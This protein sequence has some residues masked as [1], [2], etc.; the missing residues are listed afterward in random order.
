[1]YVCDYFS[2]LFFFQICL[3][4]DITGFK[5]LVSDEKMRTSTAHLVS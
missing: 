1:M 3:R 5:A 4:V 2:F